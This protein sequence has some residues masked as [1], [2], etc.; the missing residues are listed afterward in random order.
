MMM[1]KK[2]MMMMV[3]TTMKKLKRKEEE[4]EEEKT[5]KACLSDLWTVS[6]RRSLHMRRENWFWPTS[7][8]IATASGDNDDDD[9][10]K[11]VVRMT[12]QTTAANHRLHRLLRHTKGETTPMFLILSRGPNK[13]WNFCFARSMLLRG[14]LA[15]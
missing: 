13:R 10:G 7:R 4:E 12:D 15:G 11:E 14:W 1:K 9:G 3:M 5:G 6:V 8:C 2:M